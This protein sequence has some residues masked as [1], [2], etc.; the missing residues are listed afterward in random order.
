[1]GILEQRSEVKG[2]AKVEAAGSQPALEEPVAPD[3]P[4]ERELEQLEPKME[5]DRKVKRFNPHPE[6]EVEQ[7]RRDWASSLG[8]KGVLL[9][10]RENPSPAPSCG[11]WDLVL[12]EVRKART[13]NAKERKGA[14]TH[15]F[16]EFYGPFVSLCLVNTIF[17]IH[18]KFPL[19]AFLWNWIC[20][21]AWLHTA[22]TYPC[23]GATQAL[24]ARLLLQSWGSRESVKC[25]I[26]KLI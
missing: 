18:N 5:R 11:M 1:M 2:E 26:S 14:G 23:I 17:I 10:D 4:V 22:F 7:K 20:P 15:S 8:K 24:R 25:P 6:T 13:A 21:F 16:A 19:R 9:P 12:A 3:E